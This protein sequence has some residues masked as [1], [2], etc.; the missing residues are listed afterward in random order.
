[1]YI[2]FEHIL[3]G[4]QILPFTAPEFS[5]AVET[6]NTRKNKGTDLSLGHPVFCPEFSQSVE[7]AQNGVLLFHSPYQLECAF[8]FI[9]ANAGR[10]LFGRQKAVYPSYVGSDFNLDEWAVGTTFKSWIMATTSIGNVYRGY[11]YK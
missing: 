4:T 7:L 3:A 1:M 2:T 6:V 10:G 5:V 11:G 9:K 8:L